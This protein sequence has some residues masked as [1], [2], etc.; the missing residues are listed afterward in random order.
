M[1]IDASVYPVKA[2]WIV[3][4][5][6]ISEFHDILAEEL[7][8]ESL[9]CGGGS[10]PFPAYR[11]C[12]ESWPLGRKCRQDLP[13]VLEELSN[14]DAESFLLEIEAGLGALAGYEITAEDVEIRRVEK[15]RF[16]CFNNSI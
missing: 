2:G 10:R 9:A 11:T 5:P 16:C 12:T 15:R 8:V 13:T 14:V 1:L 4:G 6:N 7:N 3:G